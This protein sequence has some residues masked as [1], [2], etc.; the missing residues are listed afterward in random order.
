MINQPA[1]GGGSIEA[2]I[3]MAIET[4]D[5]EA[6]DVQFEFNGLT[7]HVRP[8]STITEIMEQWDE[9]SMRMARTDSQTSAR[10][11]IN[12]SCEHCIHKDIQE[13]CRKN[14][15]AV[16]V[17]QTAQYPTVRSPRVGPNEEARWSPACSEYSE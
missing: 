11:Y 1:M 9:K 2:A 13:R 8:R 17:G 4:A 6:D 10:F 15:P 7:I 3:R 14:P 12:L 16:I 5:S